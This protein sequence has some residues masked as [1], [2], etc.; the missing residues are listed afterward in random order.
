MPDRGSSAKAYLKARHHP[1]RVPR[2]RP[3]DT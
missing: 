1:V 3:R 2:L